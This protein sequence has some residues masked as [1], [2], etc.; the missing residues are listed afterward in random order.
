MYTPSF[1]DLV[2]NQQDFF[3]QYF[4]QKPMYRP[5]SIPVDPRQI[6]SIAEL[7]EL[8]HY[9][10][11]RRP[12][13][14]LA[15]SGVLVLPESY[16]RTQRI[17]GEMLTD[18]VTPSN[19]YEHFRAGAS[20]T[21]PTMNHYRPNLRQLCSDLGTRFSSRSEA[22]AFLT[23]AGQQGFNPHYDPG[24]LFIIQVEGS[25]HWKLWMPPEIRKDDSRQYKLEDLAEPVFEANLE[26]GDVL[27][28][29]YNTPHVAAA[30]DSMS[31]H[32]TF[33]IAPRMWST[34]LVRVVR[35]L[36]DNDP[37]FWIYP[38]MNE[39]ALDARSED[40][41]RILGLLTD[42]LA[43]LDTARE[44]EFLINVGQVDGGTAPT[45]TVFQELM[46]IDRMGG[47]TLLARKPSI[48]VSLGDSTDGRTQVKISGMALQ[49]ESARAAAETTLKLPDP[50]AMTLQRMDAGSCIRADELYPTADSRRSVEA[51][52]TLAR[53]GILTPLS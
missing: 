45:G 24:D 27:Y 2:G 50:I 26:P 53:I 44:V 42:K 1:E 52:K 41:K 5:R 34:L 40:L 37:D 12:Y 25:K 35:E 30:L 20:I 39:S 18:A 33:Q 9:Q 48:K 7:D 6:I 29:P 22:V 10:A 14:R 4:N 15:K 36:V 38:Y 32:L 43:K 8:L 11:I 19:V 16:T 17:Q 28:L 51:A 46:S 31:L 3:S 47:D 13:L 49:S 23:P 21:W